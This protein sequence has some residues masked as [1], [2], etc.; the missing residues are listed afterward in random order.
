MPPYGVA[1]VVHAFEIRHDRV[2]HDQPAVT[3]ATGGGADGV[4]IDPKARKRFRAVGH[5]DRFDD[6]DLRRDS[7]DRGRERQPLLALG[8]SAISVRPAGIAVSSEMA[9]IARMALHS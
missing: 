5:D 2:D 9:P 4:D 6:V 7:R 3:R 8:V 1:V